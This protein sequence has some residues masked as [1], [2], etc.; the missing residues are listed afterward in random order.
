MFTLLDRR[1]RRA[2]GIACL[3]VFVPPPSEASSD[4]T[5]NVNPRV[6]VVTADP[7]VRID[8]SPDPAP[9]SIAI[10]GTASDGRGHA[11]GDLFVEYQDEASFQLGLELNEQT[12]L[13]PVGGRFHFFFVDS[14]CS[15]N[16][17]TV[18]V[19]LRQGA[20]SWTVEVDAVAN[21]GSPDSTAIL[22]AESE[23]CVAAA[24]GQSFF[25]AQ[26][27]HSVVAAF[28]DLQGRRRLVGIPLDGA[29]AELHNAV[30]AIELFFWDVAPGDNSGETVVS[31]AGC[32]GPV[33]NTPTTWGRAKAAYR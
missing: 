19:T 33:G 32:S 13:G 11:F 31:L 20:S 25:G 6:H 5:V 24:V 8:T 23:G 21:C 14:E 4:P 27:F 3:V 16:E 30:G 9:V 12:E 28:E 17:G 2:A 22:V 10:A 29:S 26:P 1:I 7:V 15:D 18:E